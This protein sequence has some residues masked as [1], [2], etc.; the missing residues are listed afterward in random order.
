LLE[1]GVRDANLGTVKLLAVEVRDERN[2]TRSDDR[3]DGS[4]AP[5]YPLAL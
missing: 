1:L 2:Q 4:H 5:I 3:M